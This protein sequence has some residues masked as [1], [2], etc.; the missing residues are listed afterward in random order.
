MKTPVINNLVGGNET[1]EQ[2]KEELRV[3]QSPM[4]K[5]PDER[6]ITESKNEAGRKAENDEM[7][8]DNVNNFEKDEEEARKDVRENSRNME[9]KDISKLCNR[10]IM[11]KVCKYENS[12]GCRYT[13]KK[14]C[15]EMMTTGEC[16]MTSCS[17]GHNLEGICKNYRNDGKFKYGNNCRYMHLN[18]QTYQNEVS[19]SRS[20]GVSN[21][22]RWRRNK[23]P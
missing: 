4:E 5:V 17:Y 7:I 19:V 22:Q 21:K 15:I 11:G 16:N 1:S 9:P 13:H 8:Q 12:D 6:N 10:Y 20:V 14:L 2:S 3:D 18:L 23:H